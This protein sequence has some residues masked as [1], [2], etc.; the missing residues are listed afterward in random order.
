[1]QPGGAR[2]YV[3]SGSGVSAIDLATLAVVGHVETGRGTDGL[4]WAVRG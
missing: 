3:A 4:G 2:A 1:M